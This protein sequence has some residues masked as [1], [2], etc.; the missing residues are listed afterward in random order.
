MK[1]YRGCSESDMPI[2]GGKYVSD[3]HDA[4]EAYN[5]EAIYLNGSDDEY[6]LGFVE[7]K[8]TNGKYR[9]QLHIEKIG[10][11]SDKDIKELDDVLVVWCA[12]SDCLDFT[13][14]VGWYKNAT[15]FRYYNEVEFEDGYKQNYNIIAKAED[16]VLLPVNVR[17]RRA[18]WYV[19]RKGKKN[20]PSYG[21]GQANIWFA[22]ESDKNINLKNYLHK[23]INQI[24]NYDGENLID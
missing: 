24:N 18:L 6:C 21:F 1:N 4:H 3:T 17:S 16:C 14:I 23:I 5:F 12:K 2:N 9:N 8:T 19:P 22:N 15:V 7:T 20:G 10:N 11:Q 13:S